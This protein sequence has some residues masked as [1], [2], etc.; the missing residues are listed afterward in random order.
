M[1]RGA[2][3]MLR[4]GRGVAWPP[5]GANSAWQA[6]L[7]TH[8]AGAWPASGRHVAGCA[9]STQ[10]WLASVTWAAHGRR[11]DRQAVGVRWEV[12]LARSS[13]CRCCRRA[14]QASGQVLAVTAIM[15]RKH[16]VRGQRQIPRWKAYMLSYARAPP[17]EFWAVI[18]SV[19]LGRPREAAQASAP[20]TSLALAHRTP[21]RAR[22]DGR[23]PSAW[24]GT[25]SPSP[26]LSSRST[27]AAR[28]T[29]CRSSRAPRS[30]V[31]PHVVHPRCSMRHL[32]KSRVAHIA[33]VW[34]SPSFGR[35]HL[36]AWIAPCGGQLASVDRPIDRGSACRAHPLV[37]RQLCRDERVG[38]R[39]SRM[40]LVITASA[41]GVRVADFSRVGRCRSGPTWA[42][43]APTSPIRVLTTSP[44]HV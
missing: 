36:R 6:V 20:C 33:S 34:R 42:V 21:R 13:A 43:L 18:G 26:M 9:A 30:W 27:L 37:R 1:V 11:R 14:G 8:A 24:R 5:R 15:G 16:W 39:A 19:Q 32:G 3:L 12:R 2:V 7:H 25:S 44:S 10:S 29:W 40:G 4:R 23:A 35:G 22:A 41:Q 31:P 38:P 17:R 28:A